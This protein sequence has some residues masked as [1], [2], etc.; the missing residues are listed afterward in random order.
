MLWKAFGRRWIQLRDK[1]TPPAQGI[2]GPSQ[3]ETNVSLKGL[4]KANGGGADARAGSEPI[5]GAPC[6]AVL[7]GDHPTRAS[8]RFRWAEHC[9]TQRG[10]CSGPLV[11]NC[12]PSLALPLRPASKIYELQPMDPTFANEFVTPKAILFQCDGAGDGNRT[13]DI[14]LGKLSFYH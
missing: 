5:S 4:R 8:C 9:R 6:V 1:T 13:H 2:M 3:V 12:L 14:Q 10:T 11:A 7:I